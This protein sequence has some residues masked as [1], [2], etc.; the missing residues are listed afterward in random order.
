MDR[1][2]LE[3][4]LTAGR[5][6]ECLHAFEPRA[7]DCLYLPAGTVH[8]VGGGVLLAEVQQ[9][10]DATLRLDDWGRVGSDGKPRTL[11]VPQA[12]AAIDWASRP[13]VPEPARPLPG[14]PGERLV[15]CGY[16]VLDRFFLQDELRCPH[17]GR[18]SI[19]MVVN[20]TAELRAAGGY[21]RSFARGGTVA[22]PAATRNASWRASPSS[23]LLCVSLA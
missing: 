16:F 9:S 21:R 22:I 1:G 7:G 12:L 10:S 17:A 13:V 23:T 4:A 6:G 3:E 2:R 11:H 14:L 20:G 19:W 15:A 8:A 18:L 5:V